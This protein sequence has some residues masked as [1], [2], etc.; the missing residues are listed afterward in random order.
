MSEGTKRPEEIIQLWKNA[1]KGDIASLMILSV[2]Y[3]NGDGV[4]KNPDMSY[5]LIEKAANSGNREAYW[6]CG[7][8]KYYGIGC[9]PDQKEGREYIQKSI[10]M[11]DA[12]AKEL[13][14]RIDGKV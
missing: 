9:F 3:N 4:E 14:D 7:Y 13:L 2:A 12:Y 11:G 6:R 8:H 1:E 5:H 10:D